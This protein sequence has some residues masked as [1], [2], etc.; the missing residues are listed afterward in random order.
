MNELPALMLVV[1]PKMKENF[2]KFGDWVGFDFTFNM[3]QEKHA[4]GKEW[5]IGCF[6]GISNAKRLVP[7]GLVLSTEET[8]ERFYQIF[9]TFSNIMNKSPKIIISDEDKALMFALKAL[10]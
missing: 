4:S 7:F 1:T 10:K 2:E 6:M 5:R 8:K 9:K 3:I